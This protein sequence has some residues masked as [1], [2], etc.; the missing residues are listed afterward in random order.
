M[1]RL[2]LAVLPL[3]S[4]IEQVYAGSNGLAITPQ[5]GWN[6]WNHFG[7]DIS[8]DTILGAAQAFVNYNLTQYG[9]ECVLPL[10]SFLLLQFR[11]S[12]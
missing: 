6:T 3:L 7:C 10:T 1:L 8:E 5:M 9:Y 12:S 11:F 4:G 2:A